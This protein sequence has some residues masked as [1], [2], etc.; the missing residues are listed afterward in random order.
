MTPQLERAYNKVRQDVCIGVKKLVQEELT[1]WSL[2]DSTDFVFVHALNEGYSIAY[3]KQ[4]TK[5]S[6]RIGG[7]YFDLNWC[8]SVMYLLDIS[9][10][11][12]VRGYGHGKD[13]YQRIENIARKLNCFEIQQ[14]P[15]GKTLTRSRAA[16]LQSLG[17]VM[18]NGNAV[19][20]F[21]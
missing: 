6:E 7:T 17:Y 1:G 5:P 9:I 14:Y 3:S 21:K 18:R 20:E 19:K 16:Y 15:S 8:R 11:P 10:P 12:M 2:Y 13:L 4:G